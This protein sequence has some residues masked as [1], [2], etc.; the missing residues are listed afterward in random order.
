MAGRRCTGI[1]LLRWRETETRYNCDRDQGREVNRYVLNPRSFA[2]LCDSS[3]S[4]LSAWKIDFC[5]IFH[6]HLRQDRSPVSLSPGRSLAWKY[7]KIEISHTRLGKPNS[8]KDSGINS[9]NTAGCIYTKWI[10]PL[11]YIYWQRRGWHPYASEIFTRDS[12]VRSP[13][14]VCGFE[15]FAFYVKI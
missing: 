6:Y 1:R 11:A 5:S 10:Q 13:P 12:N 15:E 14:G 7:S 8:H 3:P 9:G 2:K 4:S